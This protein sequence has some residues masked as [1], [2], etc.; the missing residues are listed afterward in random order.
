M[1]KLTIVSFILMTFFHSAQ[2]NDLNGRINVM[3]CTD[4]EV[5]TY[6]T[7]PDPERF[8]TSDYQSF[9]R[10]H[11]Q[12]EVK[13]AETNPAVCF[14]MLYGDLASLSDQLD[15]LT[16]MFS[17]F[18]MPNV[19][20]LID[21]AMDEITKSVCE[22]FQE[23]ADGVSD[24]IKENQRALK[25][26]ALRKIEQRYG[27]SALNRYATEA[28]IPPQYQRMGLQF[29]NNTVTSDGFKRNLRGQWNDRLDELRDDA[30][31]IVKP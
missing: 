2:A 13:K 1:Y 24:F 22:R 5:R 9:E 25:K 17:G 3:E 21:K 14:G 12:Q 4:E 20:A 18:K 23:T 10:A 15:G 7:K 16:D 6:I 28:F 11:K 26:E 30:K 8:T 29:R 27:E 19:S 31:D